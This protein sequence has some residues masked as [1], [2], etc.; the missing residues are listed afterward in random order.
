VAEVVTGEAVVLAVPCARFPSRMLALL[1]DLLVEGVLLI[2]LS[3]IA[4]AAGTRL[5]AAS[6]AAVDLSAVV[7]VIVGYPTA[8]E[9]LSRGRSLGKMALGLRV[10][11]SATTAA[12]RGS[13]RHSS[14]R[15]PRS[16]RS[17]CWGVLQRLSAPC[18]RRRE[19]GL[20]TC[21]PGPS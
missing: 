3:L 13:A 16:W 12:R 9:T 7:L 2:I 10:V 19:S 4:A 18:C 6:G 21:S 5:D 11:R 20:A 1:L 15:W 17:G 14:G 8:F